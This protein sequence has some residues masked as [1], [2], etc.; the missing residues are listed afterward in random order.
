MSSLTPV[1]TFSRSP[2]LA[3]FFPLPPLPLPPL[4]PFGLFSSAIRVLVPRSIGVPPG[5]CKTSRANVPAP[6][7]N[8][9]QESSRI[10]EVRRLPFRPLVQPRSIYDDLSIWRQFDLRAIHGA[11]R[12]TF[13]VDALAVVA[14][15]VAGTLEFI[16]AGLPVGRGTQMGTAGVDHEKTIRRAI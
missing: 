9:G 1:V 15:A 3:P 2:T 10:V 7:L 12:R 13:E 6:H 11:R 14:A 16:F 5:C 8:S 4:P